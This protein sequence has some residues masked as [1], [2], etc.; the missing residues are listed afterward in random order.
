MFLLNGAIIV[1]CIIILL[2]TNAQLASTNEM[3]AYPFDTSDYD[4]VPQ[5]TPSNPSSLVLETPLNQNAED[6]YLELENRKCKHLIDPYNDTSTAD[7][8][9]ILKRYRLLDHPTDPNACYF[10][11][12]DTLVE[13]NCSTLNSYLFDSSYNDVISGIGAEKF[14]DPYVAK[15]IVDDQCTIVFNSNASVSRKLDYANFIDNNDPKT[16]ALTAQKK[17]EEARIINMNNQINDLTNKIRGMEDKIN[18]DQ[19]TIDSEQ[20]TK[21]DWKKTKQTFIDQ[22]NLYVNELNNFKDAPIDDNATGTITVESNKCRN[23]DTGWQNTNRDQDINFLDRHNIECKAGE[24]ITQ[25]ALNASGDGAKSVYKCCS[26]NPKSGKQNGALQQKST[27]WADSGNW[28]LPYLDRHVIDCGDSG[29]INQLRMETRGNTAVHY[30]YRCQG[31][32]PDPTSSTICTE[33]TTEKRA[34][35]NRMNYLDKLPINCPNGSGLS[36]MKFETDPSQMWYRYKCCT[37]EMKQP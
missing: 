33:Y 28:D 17:I 16:R 15:T 3:F 11:M 20:R 30:N 1:A 37:T 24:Y 5:M 36:F 10:K 27:Q 31:L 25:L 4:P 14:N 35:S 21:D 23:M 8:I 12:N 6:A 34:K 2:Y 13:D 26:I 22:L 32:N 7:Q 19:A 9:D 29:L 18:K